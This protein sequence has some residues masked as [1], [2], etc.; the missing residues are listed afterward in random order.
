MRDCDVGGKAWQCGAR[1]G[2]VGPMK[3]QMNPIGV[4]DVARGAAVQGSAAQIQESLSNVHFSASCSMDRS[5]V[6]S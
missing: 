1:G 3:E 4:A 6:H 2:G 5:G